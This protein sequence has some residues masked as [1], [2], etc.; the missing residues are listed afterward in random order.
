MLPSLGSSLISEKVVHKTFGSMKYSQPFFLASVHWQAK[1][2]GLNIKHG[3]YGTSLPYIDNDGDAPLYSAIKTWKLQFAIS[4]CTQKANI[5]T[6][7][8]TTKICPWYFPAE[9]SS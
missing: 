2:L 5:V 4:D 9:Y 7:A 3:F 6:A 1:G 8:F